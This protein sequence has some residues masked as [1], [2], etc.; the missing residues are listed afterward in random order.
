LAKKISFLCIVLL[1]GLLSACDN[2]DHPSQNSTSGLFSICDNTFIVSGSRKI[3]LFE[4]QPNSVEFNRLAVFNDWAPLSPF[5]ECS[6]NR[7][8]VP[9]GARR[10]DRNNAGVAIIDLLSG[11]KV[12]YPV[13]SK[14]IQGIPLKYRDGLLLSSNL[15]HQTKPS[16]TPPVYGY[17]PPGESY[18]DSRGSSYRLF[19]P[20]TYF[21][22]SSLEFTEELDLDLGYSVIENNMLYAKQRGAITAIDLDSKTTKVLYESNHNS[23]AKTENIPLNHL[24]VFLDADYFMVLNRHS[25]NNTRGQLDGFEKNAIYKLVDGRMKKLRNMPND[26]A[27][28]LLGLEKK[29]F[30]FTH[31]LKVI[32]YNIETRSLVERNLPNLSSKSGYSIESVGYTHQNFIMT[33]ASQRADISSKVILFS[34]D[35]SQASAVKDVDLRLVS[36]TSDLAIDTSDSRGIKLPVVKNSL[37]D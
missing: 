14:G 34:R 18:K 20:T 17:L 37:L 26:D 21:D 13:G 25:E 4:H 8:I 15:L 6:K 2:A 1:G 23:F 19:T 22:L 12:E 5:L 29:L 10:D 11:N 9:Y 35:F 31:S 16:I 7:I 32:E 28:Y 24:G 36:V 33:L 3:Y 30:I 27:V